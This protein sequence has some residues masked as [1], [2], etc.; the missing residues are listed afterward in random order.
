[1][2]KSLLITAVLFA[3]MTSTEASKVIGNAVGSNRAQSIPG[4]ILIGLLFAIILSLVIK[5]TGYVL[6]GSE[7]SFEPVKTSIESCYGGVP[8]SNPL[9]DIPVTTDADIA[10]RA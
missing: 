6:T 2:T 1:M 9:P 3:L 8:P 7:V 4:R 5:R 10:H